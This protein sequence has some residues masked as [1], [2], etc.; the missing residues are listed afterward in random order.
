MFN[1]D[2]A[3]FAMYSAMDDPLSYEEACKEEKWIQAMNAEMTAI[4]R[5]NTWKLVDPPPGIKPIGVKW[6]FKTKNK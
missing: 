5:N 3:G 6:V 1:D 4:E 2:E